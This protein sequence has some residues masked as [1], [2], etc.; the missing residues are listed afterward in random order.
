M[1]RI[2]GFLDFLGGNLWIFLSESQKSQRT[3]RTQ[4]RNVWTRIFRISGLAG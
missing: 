2:F 1:F 3:R 4:K